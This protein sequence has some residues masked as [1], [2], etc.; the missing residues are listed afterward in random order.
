M[1]PSIAS[2]LQHIH[3]EGQL[4]GWH[5]FLGELSTLKL[6]FFR[7]ILRRWINLTFGEN[8]FP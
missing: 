6:F 7:G 8:L 3:L 2:L 1:A 5:G 4:G